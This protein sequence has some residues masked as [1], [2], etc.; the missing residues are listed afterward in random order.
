MTNGN[1]TFP[2]AQHLQWQLNCDLLKHYDP[3]AVEISESDLGGLQSLLLACQA[4]NWRDSHCGVW[5]DR[6]TFIRGHE[7]FINFAKLLQ[8]KMNSS[9][10]AV[11]LLENSVHLSR[12]RVVLRLVRGKYALEAE[13]SISIAVI[14]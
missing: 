11:T 8:S 9:P 6:A 1:S 5:T 7:D 4:E 10:K 2:Y 3:A 12:G 14:E 13:V